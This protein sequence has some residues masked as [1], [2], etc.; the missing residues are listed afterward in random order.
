M[1]RDQRRGKRGS[2]SAGFCARL[3]RRSHT[4]RC[5]IARGRFATSETGQL[6]PCPEALLYIHAW[7]AALMCL[8]ACRIAQCHER[9]SPSQS[10]ACR[11]QLSQRR[12]AAGGLER[13][14]HV[15]HGWRGFATTD[16]VQHTSEGLARTFATHGSALFVPP[17]STASEAALISCLASQ[18]VFG[19]GAGLCL[20]V[21]CDPRAAL[22]SPA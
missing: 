5:R 4:V 1:G 7:T 11:R 19:C 6:N 20:A 22:W 9:N 16:G 15:V 17:R 10:P 12:A 13:P 18:L 3:E 2:Q 8:C 21:H 14:T